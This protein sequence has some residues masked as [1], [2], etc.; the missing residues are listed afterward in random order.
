M[1]GRPISP[2]DA[3]IDPARGADNL[4]IHCAG[5][6]AGDSVL[7][8]REPVGAGHYEDS[9]PDFIAQR[10]RLLGAAVTILAEPLGLGPEDCPE[11]VIAAMAGADHTIFLSRIGD[12]IR[13][14]PLPGAGS[15]TMVYALDAEHL[16][17][18]FATLPYALLETLHDRL[19]DRLA[20]AGAYRIRDDDGSE[21]VM[22]L[23]PRR[24][25]RANSFTVKNFPV[26]VIPPISAAGLSGRLKLTHALTS[27]YIHVYEESVLPLT[28][29]VW[30]TL[31]DGAIIGFE[32]EPALV[33]EVRAQFERVA[34]LLGGEALRVN[35]W[36]V[37]INPGVFFSK[38]ALS[39]I[40]RWSAV[41]FGSPRYT[42][43]H[44][45]GSAP[46][47]ICGQMFDPV[48]AFDDEVV[49]DR[50]RLL[51]FDR[52]ENQSLLA[53]FGLTPSALQ[54]RPDIGLPHV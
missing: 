14:Q 36:H 18:L 38:P 51:F 50:G 35:S 27:T 29:P 53:D 48:I 33:A 2:P 52:P 32:G 3:S 28:S 22:T 54:T 7:V 11:A 40:D 25:R 10:A 30:L 4:L 6:R 13:F 19:V 44:M 16:G 24:E 8:V 31:E 5:V 47:D 26:M 49:W 12:Q 39:D 9:L 41:A 42:H 23:E 34:G 15:K 37:G 1:T 17:S 20:E 43:F 21:L 45:C 46:G